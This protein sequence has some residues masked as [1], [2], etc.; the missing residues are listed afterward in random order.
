MKIGR[1]TL[2]GVSVVLL[3][4][5]LGIVSTIAA[6]YLYQ[7]WRCPRVWTR[8]AAIDPSLPM[9]GR[10]LS[11]QLTVDGCQS[12][13]PSAKLATFPRDYSGAV[14]PGPYV[15]RP[16]ATTFRANLKVIGNKLVAVRAEGQEDPTV[17]EE[18][19]AA[20]GVPCDQM[21]LDSG[22]DF[23]IANTAQS[24]LP[25][26]PGQELWIE[27]TVPPKGPPRPIQLALK[28]DGAWK[29]LAF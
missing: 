23:Y 29:P 1:R 19:S 22:V 25:L 5:Q 9:R 14:K 13:L 3:V 6:K 26:K 4:I 10:Y 15:L 12:T 18:V 17:G 20:P 11:L 2:S 8:A 21:L 27:V 24:P 7:R 28:Q 16:Q